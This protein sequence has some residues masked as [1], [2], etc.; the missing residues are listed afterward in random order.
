LRGAYTGDAAWARY[1]HIATKC[2]TERYVTMAAP[3]HVIWDDEDDPE[4]N[5][6]HVA[7]HGLTTADVAHVLAL[8]AGQSVSSSTGRPMAFGYTPSGEYIVVVFEQVDA[9]TVYPV[10]AYEVPEPGQ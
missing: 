10:T 4:G 9:D 3:L 6:Q 7:E 1:Y 8:P 2:Y 5:V